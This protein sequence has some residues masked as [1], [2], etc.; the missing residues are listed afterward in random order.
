MIQTE[1]RMSVKIAKQIKEKLESDS[2]ELLIIER[3]RG[4]SGKL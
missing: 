3:D 4:T 2:M 1:I